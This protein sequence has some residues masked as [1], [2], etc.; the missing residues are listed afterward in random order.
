[1]G[2]LNHIEIITNCKEQM[3]P[4]DYSRFRMLMRSFHESTCNNWRKMHGK[5]MR[6]WVHLH[7]FEED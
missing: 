3:L 5:P 6:R 7:K 2:E 4:K 1:M